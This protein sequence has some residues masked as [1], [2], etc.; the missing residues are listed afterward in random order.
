MMDKKLHLDIRVSIRQA[1]FNGGAL[2]INE[3]I[4]LEPHGFMEIC[5]ILSQ[6]HRLAEKLK[7]QTNP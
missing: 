1:D 3:S 2:E 7:G 6:F 4:E 5:E